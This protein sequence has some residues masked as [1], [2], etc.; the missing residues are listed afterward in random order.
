M[1]ENVTSFLPVAGSCGQY[2]KLFDP[3]KEGE[4]I[5][6]ITGLLVYHDSSE[7]H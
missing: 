3:F 2:S 5:D 1:S 7:L 6:E 4:F